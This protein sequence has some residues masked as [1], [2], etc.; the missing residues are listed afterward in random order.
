M[1]TELITEVTGNTFPDS[2]ALFKP[3]ILHS[4]D[5]TTGGIDVDSGLECHIT[6]Y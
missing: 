1:R 5:D 3:D 6:I 4:G 2:D